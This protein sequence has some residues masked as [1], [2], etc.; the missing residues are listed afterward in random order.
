MTPSHAPGCKQVFLDN[1]L[2]LVLDKQEHLEALEKS[3]Q[4][5]TEQCQPD[6]IP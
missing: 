2:D 1:Q 4:E 3:A 5:T 6:T